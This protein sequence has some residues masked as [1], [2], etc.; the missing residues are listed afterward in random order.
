MRANMTK[1]SLRHYWL[2]ILLTQATALFATSNRLITGRR[3]L[4]LTKLGRV[5]GLNNEKS[6]VQYIMKTDNAESIPAAQQAQS[7]TSIY[8]IVLFIAFIGLAV[9]LRS[10]YTSLPSVIDFIKADLHINSQTAGLLS[11]I[12]IFCFGFLM[13]VMSSAVSRLGVDRAVIVTL[14]GIAAGVLL[15][16][17][18]GVSFLFLGTFV[19][20]AAMTMGNLVALMVISRDFRRQ[21][22]IITGIYVI[23]MSAGSMLTAGVTAPLSMLIG[24]PLALAFWSILAFISLF[25]WALVFK[26]R[27]PQ[28]ASQNAKSQ[29][30]TSTAQKRDQSVQP[31]WRRFNVWLLAL[32]FAAHTFM[33]YAL[34]AWFPPYLEEVGHMSLAKAGTVAS[35]FQIVA[36]IGCF[37]VPWMTRSGKFSRAML[38]A[39][40]SGSWFIMIAGFI[41]A[42]SWWVIWIMFGGIGS[43]G[44]FLVV[45]MLVM[46]LAQT[47]DENRRISSFVQGV[48][49]IIASSGP[50]FVGYLHQHSGNW[51]LSFS[52]L[53]LLAV[54]MGTMGV[55]ASRSKPVIQSK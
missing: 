17:G 41:I 15:R 16:S 6:G 39:I 47:L 10:P 13:P 1:K 18:P 8:Q 4:R 44:G 11:S 25:F 46:D 3:A 20:G 40:V 50:T 23:A 2:I 12:P 38:F 9:N 53:A 22:D 26:Y 14:I 27:R 43:G 48:G 37:L 24:W 21:S 31:T 54:A 51:Q 49:Y 7:R 34:T 30:A 42:P 36:I 52:V 29:P 19:M 32:C 35:F 33:F 28:A 5:H 55:I 45:F